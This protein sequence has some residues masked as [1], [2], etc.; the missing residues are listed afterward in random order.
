MGFDPAY[1]DSYGD[2][3]ITILKLHCEDCEARYARLH[4]AMQ[5]IVKAL[6]LIIHVD[7]AQTNE[8]DRYAVFLLDSID[9]V[10]TSGVGK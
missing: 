10:P 1:R 2:G 9:D 8:L 4:T 3:R 5:Q 7:V 6:N